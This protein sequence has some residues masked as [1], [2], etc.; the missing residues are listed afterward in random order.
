MNDLIVYGVGSLRSLRVHWML[1]ELGIS[2]KTELIQ[3]RSQQMQTSA[4][5]AIHPGRKIPSL[6]DGD[7]IISESAAICLYLAERYGG[8]KFLPDVEIEQRARFFQ[9][10]FYVMTELDA[11]TLYVIAKHGGSLVQYYKPSPEAVEVAINGF[12]QQILVAES[13]LE[14]TKS[15]ILG[16]AFT[17]AD[18]LL[19]TCLMSALR[20]AVQ[21]PLQIPHKLIVYAENLQA[22]KAFQLA[23]IANQKAVSV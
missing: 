17:V 2:Y 23:E 9:V 16:G 20:L 12:N 8:G 6:Q 3:S 22:R 1:Q 5:T 14:D 4:Y 19:C 21:F 13:W 18:I 10:C 11:H 15:Y 7:L